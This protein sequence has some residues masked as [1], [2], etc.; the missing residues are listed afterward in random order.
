M[1]LEVVRSG[2]ASWAWKAR[3]AGWLAS[4]SSP[5]AEEAQYAARDESARHLS[6]SPAAEPNADDGGDPASWTWQSRLGRASAVHQSGCVLA[7]DHLADDSWCWSVDDPRSG[8]GAT[9]T[10]SSP[11]RARRAALAALERHLAP[12]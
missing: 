2:P 9:G 5:T 10:A 7:V 8:W 1:R 6:L 3:G 11:D 12:S 4:G